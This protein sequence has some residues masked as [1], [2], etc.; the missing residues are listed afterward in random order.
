MKMLANLQAVWMTI[1]TACVLVRGQASFGME[2]PALRITSPKDGSV[3]NPGQSLTVTVEAF[4]GPVK[5]VFI[6][7]EFGFSEE[8][9]TPP[10]KY[11]IHVPANAKPGLH[12][13]TA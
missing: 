13:L 11:V 8:V 4:G 9:L 10:Y 6:V 1:I 2:Q 7:G 12:N 5:G 3:V